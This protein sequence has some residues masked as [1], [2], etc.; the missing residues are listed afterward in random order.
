[1]VPIHTEPGQEAHETVKLTI[2]DPVLD[3][4]TVRDRAKIKA[5][6][7]NHHAMQLAWYNGQT[8]QGC[9]IKSG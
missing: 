1:M 3:F 7:I 4:N 2:E 5:L 6:E 9:L 8:G